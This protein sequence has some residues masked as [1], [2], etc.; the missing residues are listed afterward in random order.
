MKLT[1]KT[2]FILLLS[3][4]I[5]SLLFPSCSTDDLACSGQ[6]LQP[7]IRYEVRRAMEVKDDFA[8]KPARIYYFMLDAPPQES[9]LL[10]KSIWDLRNIR[11]T[12]YCHQETDHQNYGTLAATGA[13]LR[14]GAVCSAA[15]DWSRYPVGTKFRIKSQPGVVYE[16][17]DYGSA[18]VGSSTI[19]LYRPTLG[20]MNEWGVRAVDIEI[21][22]W[23][24]YEDSLRLMR[25]RTQY[26]HV[27]RMYLDIQ[28][29]LDQ[30]GNRLIQSS[31]ATVM[32]APITAA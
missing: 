26:P 20:G 4:S 28:K 5:S 23:G 15:A 30:A 19:D 21:V 11:T 32:N 14:F 12:A 16:V 17:D 31:P 18:L 10:A 8:T 7:G 6:V 3:A 9:T 22:K 24:S 2:K 29:H 25:D 27:R 13:P 1:M